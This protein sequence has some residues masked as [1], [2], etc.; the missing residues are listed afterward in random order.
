MDRQNRVK[1]DSPEITPTGSAVG[2]RWTVGDVSSRGFQALRLS[3]LGARQV[4]GPRAAYAVCLNSLP[5]EVARAR[6]GDVAHQ[7]DW[8]VSDGR[9]PAFLRDRLDPT[10]AEGVA[11]KFAPLRLFPDRHEIAF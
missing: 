11:W 5:M 9:I 2:I 3:I 10:L 1:Q 6:L 8:H 7:V 4:F